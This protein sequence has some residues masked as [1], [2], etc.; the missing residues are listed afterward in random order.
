MVCG[1]ETVLCLNGD[2]LAC[3]QLVDGKPIF[4]IPWVS[5]PVEKNN[6]CQPI[7]LNGN[8]SSTQIFVSSGYGRGS[9]VFE[10]KSR[11]NQLE[12][13]EVWKNKNL[14]SKFSCA[15]TQGNF[16]YGLDNGILTCLSLKDGR[17]L[18]KSGRY[19]HG[20]LIRIGNDLIVLSEKG[21]LAQVKCDPTQFSEV[22][23]IAALNNRTWNHP[24]FDGRFL[25]IRNSELAICF[26]VALERFE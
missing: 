19:G 24:A 1:I 5:N 17:K 10:I 6:V 12:V 11:K 14:K 16:V 15:V 2:G 20:Q 25:L 22:A 21:E 7:V 8:S 9:A 13:Q 23:R 3:H 26:E 4:F 18:W